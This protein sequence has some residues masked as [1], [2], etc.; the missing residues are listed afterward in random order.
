[1]YTPTQRL[2]RSR[3]ER[4]IAGVAGGIAQYMGIDPVIVRLA[5]IA[6]V[7]TGVG[8]LLY[9]IL[10]VIMPQEGSNTAVPGQAFDEMRR[11]ASRVEREVFSAFVVLQAL[12]DSITG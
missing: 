7:F 9:P 5:M 11:E 12:F 2:M 10:W 4:M 6:L 1:M 8:I 3:N